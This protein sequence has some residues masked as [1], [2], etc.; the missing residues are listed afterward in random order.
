MDIFI[1]P[2]DHAKLLEDSKMTGGAPGPAASIT[3]IMGHTLHITSAAPVGKALMHIPPD[4]SFRGGPQDHRR[5]KYVTR[6]TSFK[7]GQV[8]EDEAA[9]Q[10][11]DDFD[12]KIKPGLVGEW[13]DDPARMFDFIGRVNMETHW[14]DSAFFMTT[15]G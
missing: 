12:P 13:V 14:I 4:P 6:S 15:N 1:N 7:S 9:Q 11:F 10:D 8:V 2:A 3:G 5:M